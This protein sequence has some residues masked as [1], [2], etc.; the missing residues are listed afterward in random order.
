VSSCS[1]SFSARN[2]GSG[3][4]VSVLIGRF[5]GWFATGHT[6][7]PATGLEDSWQIRAPR[8]TR[9]NRPLQEGLVD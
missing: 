3:D 5:Y 2:P 6:N 1:L 7:A 8:G 9:A 4:A